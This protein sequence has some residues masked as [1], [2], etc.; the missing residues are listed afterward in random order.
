M[1]KENVMKFGIIGFGKI[2]RKFVKSIEATSEGKVVAIGSKS[3]K[4]EDEFIVEHPEVAVYRD[5]QTMLEQSGI[6]AVYV[7]VPHQDHFKWIIAA[8]KCKIAV[9]SEKPAVLTLE[10]MEEVL[11]VAKENDTYFSEALKTRYNEG[12]ASL[13]KD[14]AQ[15]GELVKIEAN[16]CFDATFMKGSGTYLFDQDQGGALNDVGPYLTAFATGL[17]GNDF[18]TV[19]SVTRKEGKIP[20]YFE[21]TVKYGNGATAVLEGAIDQNKERYALLTGTKGSIMVPVFNRITEY[22]ITPAAGEP[23]TK[24]FTFTGDDMTLEIDEVIQN[25]KNHRIESVWYDHQAHLDNMKLFE[26]IKS[27]L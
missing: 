15:I 20:T 21:A 22:T 24:E 16:F 2:A 9:L 4:E 7:A 26:A 23:N 19:T 25:S 17:L 11:K 12:F 3:V 5:Y 14:L 10:E 13:K 6:D 27:S 18:Q 1:C 8:L